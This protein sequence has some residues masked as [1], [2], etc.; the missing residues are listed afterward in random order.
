M[1]SAL[2][3]NVETVWMHVHCKDT[4]EISSVWKAAVEKDNETK[5]KPCK[6]SFILC[7]LLH[8]KIF[9][10]LLCKTDYD[11]KYTFTIKKVQNIQVYIAMKKKNLWYD[12]NNINFPTE[13]QVLRR[14]SRFSPLWYLQKAWRQRNIL[15]IDARVSQCTKPRQVWR[16]WLTAQANIR[17]SRG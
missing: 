2:C 1:F 8:L 6:V 7:F 5:E 13:M 12:V 15:R 16:L 4:N 3:L 17:T 10:W 14:E 9:V 11:N